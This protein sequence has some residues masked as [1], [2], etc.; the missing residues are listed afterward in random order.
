[1]VDENEIVMR[2]MA[3]LV[4]AGFPDPDNYL[5]ISG[6]RRYPGGTVVR[7]Y[8]CRMCKTDYLL[9]ISLLEHLYKE[10]GFERP[11]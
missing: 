8:K 7:S 5:D 11:R 2:M 6:L 9:T 3:D 10:H 4:E 1:M